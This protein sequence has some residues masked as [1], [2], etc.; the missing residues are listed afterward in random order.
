MAVCIRQQHQRFD[1]EDYDRS[2]GEYWRRSPYIATT[3]GHPSQ[4]GKKSV[5]HHGVSIQTS[6][7]ISYVRRQ[8][9]LLF[10]PNT[11]SFSGLVRNRDI[12]FVTF[13]LSE[14]LW[15]FYQIFLRK[16]S[17]NSSGDFTRRPFYDSSKKSTGD[18]SRSFSEGFSGNSSGHASRISSGCCSSMDSFG[19]FSSISS[20]ISRRILP[21]FS[22]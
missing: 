3:K 20:E 14:F 16:F 9:L 11:K 7:I 10:S 12:F 1:G 22:L 4:V 17:R 2:Y 18:S 13:F 6:V 19:Y 21:E 15:R 5:T 8:T